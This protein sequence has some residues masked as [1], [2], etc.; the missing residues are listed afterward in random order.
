VIAHHEA[1]LDSAANGFGRR[2]A[3]SRIVIG[4]GLEQQRHASNLARRV[5]AERNHLDGLPTAAEIRQAAVQRQQ[6]HGVVKAVDPEL[7]GAHQATPEL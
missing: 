5:A 1:S 3:T 7:P 6:L 2:L 4:H